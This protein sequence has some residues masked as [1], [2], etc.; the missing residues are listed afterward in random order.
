M[1]SPEKSQIFLL[2]RGKA[3]LCYSPPHSPDSSGIL[4]QMMAIRGVVRGSL[5]EQ[6]CN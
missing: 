2:R 6:E 4:V 1:L 5:V 3:V